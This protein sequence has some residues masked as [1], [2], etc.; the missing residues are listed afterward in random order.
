MGGGQDNS[1][2]TFND[3]KH[4][5]SGPG[6]TRTLYSAVSLAGKRWEIGGDA[7]FYV[8]VVKPLRHFRTASGDSASIICAD[9]GRR[10]YQFY[11]LFIQGIAG[12]VVSFY[13]II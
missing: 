8:Q 7:E 2:G 13:E 12:R 1:E 5:V 11:L 10:N 4:R 9:F 6:I 3:P